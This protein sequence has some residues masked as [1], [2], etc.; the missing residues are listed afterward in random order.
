MA[1]TTGNKEVEKM[2]KKVIVICS[3]VLGLM[4]LGA[5]AVPAMAAGPT[6]SGAAPTLSIGGKAVL[7]TRLLLIKNEAK[8]DALLAKGVTNGKLTTIQAGQVKDFWTA[9]HTQF[10]KRVAGR[11]LSKVQ[12][13]AT[14]KDFLGQA[15]SNG[16]ITQ[17]QAD[18][19]IAAWEKM[20][21]T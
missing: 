20:H 15:V 16:K 8:V 1:Y 13:E 11:F 19:V 17:A 18:K 2:L 10:T 21:T 9:H 12:D 6:A 3:V 7:L 4:V 5:F 14:L